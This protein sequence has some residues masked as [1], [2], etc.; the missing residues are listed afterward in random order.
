MPAKKR[1]EDWSE[2]YRRRMLRGRRLGKTPSESYSHPRERAAGMTTHESLMGIEDALNL[3][4]NGMSAAQAARR[5]HISSST[6]YSYLRGGEVAERGTGNRWIVSRSKTVWNTSI[7]VD[8]KIVN[9]TV[10]AENMSKVAGYWNSLRAAKEHN[11]QTYLD[12]IEGLV[13][14]DVNGT[15]YEP[16][17]DMYMVSIPTG[18]ADIYQKSV[19]M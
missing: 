14:V 11:D 6:L 13:V 18:I 16:D 12:F 10:D 2:A 7:F 19:I 5:A 4:A 17:T 3:M 9:I 8:G 1:E 15:S